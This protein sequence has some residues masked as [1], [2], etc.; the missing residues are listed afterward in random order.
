MP[1]ARAGSEPARRR[2]APRLVAAGAV[3]AIAGLIVALVAFGHPDPAP[4]ARPKAPTAAYQLFDGGTATL[5]DHR[6]RPLVVNFWASWCT[7]CAAELPELQ[8]AH[9]RWGDRVA[10]VGLTHRDDRAQARAMATSAGVTY[11][12]GDD[13]DGE[14]YRALGLVAMPSTAFVDAHGKVQAVVA[15]RLDDRALQDHVD[16]LLAEG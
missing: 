4:A 16:Q 9:E 13:A 1:T 7:P 2:L 11:E 5:A 14:L 12:L 8:A 10:V 15:G 6:G 3:G